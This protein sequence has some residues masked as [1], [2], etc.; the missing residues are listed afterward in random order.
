[1]LPHPCQSRLKKS[2]SLL[3]ILTAVGVSGCASG[4][5]GT[6]W[7]IRCLELSGE[8]RVA[9][10]E[11]VAESL[12]RTPGIR[13]EEVFVRT[14]ADGFSRLYYGRYRRSTFRGEKKTPF[15]RKMRADL[16]LLR[17]LGDSTGR[18]FFSASL[19]VRMPEANTGNP[20]WQ[21]KRLDA[22]YSLQVAVFEPAGEFWECKRAAAQYCAA[23]RDKGF[24]AYYHHGPGGSV[25]TVG[26]F[27]PNAVY[28]GSDGKTYYAA[29]VIELQQHELLKY[30]RLNG[31]IYRARVGSGD[32]IRV[33]SRL[34]EVPRRQENESHP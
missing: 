29:E 20:A 28:R 2:L 26:A 27:G 5:R 4:L 24:D 19:P 3:P 14:H 31:R 17:E 13:S 1:M 23:L 32:T 25:V 21:L 6:P 10:I 7:T 15:P 8:N 22:S 30:N 11:Q 33:R 16:N 18:R 9:A 34:V 12:R